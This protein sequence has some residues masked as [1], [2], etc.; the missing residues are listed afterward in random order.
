[1]AAIPATR[2]VTGHILLVQET[3]FRLVTDDGQGY[4]LTLAHDAN[5]EP[6]DLERLRHANSRV[7]VEYEGA[8]N[9]VSGKARRVRA[10]SAPD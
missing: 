6:P 3:R 5:V 7:E 4:L 1:M 2:T 9:L 10:V 8:P